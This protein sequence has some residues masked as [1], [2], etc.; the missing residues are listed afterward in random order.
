MWNFLRARST[1]KT[2][3]NRANARVSFSYNKSIRECQKRDMALVR[4]VAFLLL[5]VASSASLLSRA[6]IRI[7][8]FPAESAVPVHVA[9]PFWLLAG[10]G[11]LRT[12]KMQVLP[13]SRA[14]LESKYKENCHSWKSSYEDA[15]FFDTF[16]KNSSEQG[17]FFVELG[18]LD[19]SKYSNTWVLEKILGWRG[20]LI[21]PNPAN[22]EQVRYNRPNAIAINT[23]VCS[24]I[25]EV[26]FLISDPDR[27]DRGGILEFMGDEF[28]KTSHPSFDAH[29]QNQ[30]NALPRTTCLP[31]QLV[32]DLFRITN[33]DFLSLDVEGAEF[34]VIKTL[35]LTRTYIKWIVIEAWGKNPDK[36]AMVKNYVMS[37]GL[38]EFHGHVVHNDWFVRK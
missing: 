31:L 30:V 8:V 10:D 14:S 26:H 17:G 3:A 22:F 11:V 16:L 27:P 21:E 32:F 15:Y 7:G 9:L 24:T 37:T 12:P 19:G 6:P 36:D 28:L 35:N 5:I 18:A 34:E 4:G 23:A 2:P 13:S 38:Y 25:Q 20:L 29:D 33:I 1:V